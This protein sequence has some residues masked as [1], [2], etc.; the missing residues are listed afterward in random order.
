MGA[1]ESWLRGGGR[2][3]ERVRPLDLVTIAAVPVVLIVVFALPESVRQSL[4][5]DYTD[6]SVR[7]ALLSPWVHLDQTH[8][9]INVVGYV[10]VVPITYVLGVSNGRRTHFFVVFTTVLIAFPP[11]LS[12]LNLAAPRLAAA[13]GFSGVL[14][15]FVGQLGFAIADH[16]GRTLKLDSPHALVPVFFFAGTAVVAPMSIRSVTVDRMTVYLGTSGLVAAALLSGLLFG[17]GAFDGI[18]NP[19]RRFRHLTARRG[20]FGLAIVAIVMFFGAQTLAFPPQ[21]RGSEVS[22]NL[23]THLM[24]YSLGFLVPYVGIE[25]LDGFDERGPQGLASS[26]KIKSR[27]P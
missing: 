2:I 26:E 18:E 27:D 6:P 14:L 16:V 25:L 23:Y 11:T 9:L 1:V 7:T 15:A 24:G 17:L 21:P 22:V 19:R 13:L 12:Y 4:A 20:R 8:L 10:L 5:F 3:R